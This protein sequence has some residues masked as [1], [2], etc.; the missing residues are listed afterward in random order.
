MSATNDSPQAQYPV[1][2]E[3]VAEMARLTKQATL[4]TEQL[5][6]LP[7]MLPLAGLRSIL[8]IGCGPGEWVFKVASANQECRVQGIDISQV[9]TDY[10]SQIA[11]EQDLT[12]VQ[13]KIMD[14]RQPL[15]LPDESF[16]FIHARLIMTFLSATNWPPLLR[17]CLRLLKPGGV[18]CNIELERLGITTSTSFTQ[19]QSFF[20]E[21]LRQAGHGFVAAGN[22]IG[23]TAVQERLLQDAGF[24]QVRHEAFMINY[25]TGQPAHAV[26]CENCFTAMK[27]GLPF[28]ERS[29]LATRRD[30]EVLYERAQIEMQA[31]DF[32]GVLMLQRVW[33][34]KPPSP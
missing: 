1:D 34:Q 4:L 8:D 20:V 27:L 16:D 25:S 10:A 7:A 30:L 31:E 24:E 11:Y 23:I 6:L 2:A 14:A 21:A 26:M 29:G 17:D 33:G 12:N 28:L 5:G 15:K 13:F 19:F 32:C 3:N 22:D 9:M 18:L